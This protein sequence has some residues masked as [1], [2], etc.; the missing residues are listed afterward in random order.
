MIAQSLWSTTSTEQVLSSTKYEIIAEIRLPI[1]SLDLQFEKKKIPRK[2]GKK[3]NIDV[4][5][6]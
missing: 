5:T 6:N 2:L 1:V 4:K 3:L